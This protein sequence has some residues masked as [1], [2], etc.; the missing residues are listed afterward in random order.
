ML[1]RSDL[2]LIN[3]I[4][5]ISNDIL[6]AVLKFV[7]VDCLFVIQTNENIKIN[8]LECI[9]VYEPENDSLFKN[10]VLKNDVENNDF[11]MI[12]FTLMKFEDSF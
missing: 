10:E 1:F 6:N 12:N 7:S 5:T 11:E 3:N 8:T 2:V 4:E 9:N